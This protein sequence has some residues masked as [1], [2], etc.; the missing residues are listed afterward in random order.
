MSP[1]GSCATAP[2]ERVGRG[3]G[4]LVLGFVALGVLDTLWCAVPMM[5]CSVLLLVG[6]VTGWCPTDLLAR[7]PARRPNSLG[8]VDATHVVTIPRR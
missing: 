7:R 2:S 8:Y 5:V 6:A 1:R 3:V 4:G